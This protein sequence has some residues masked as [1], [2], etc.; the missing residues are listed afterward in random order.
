MHIIYIRFE[1]NVKQSLRVLRIIT[2][3]KNVFHSANY[4]II[5]NF[6]Y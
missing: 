3:T 4:E 2:T 1:N 6:D 5:Y